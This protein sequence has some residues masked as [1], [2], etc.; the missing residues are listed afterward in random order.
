MDA[1]DAIVI[2]GRSGSGKTSLADLLIRRFAGVGRDAQVLRVED[3]YPGWDGLAAG[4]AAVASALET[5]SYRRYDWTAG[6]FGETVRIDPA[7][8]LIVE[9]CGAV[10]SENLRALTD[11][12]RRVDPALPDPAPLDRAPAAPRIWSVWLELPA[13]ERRLRALERDGATFAPHWQRWADQED[14][15]YAAH[16][17]WELV[18][19]VLRG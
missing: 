15:H 9:G 18:D 19:E 14:T 11:W 7:L 16:T 5:G 6:H 2:D 1:L 17:P 12:V 8:P 13:E 4:S 10:T 3:L